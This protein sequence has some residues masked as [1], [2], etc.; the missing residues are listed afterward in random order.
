[1]FN[2]N[3]SRNRRRMCW[4]V[5]LSLGITLSMPFAAWSAKLYKWIDENG[6][7]RYSDR[8]PADQSKKRFQTLAPDGRVLQTKEEA[9]SPE[10]LRQEREEKQR[11]EEEARRIE[12][13][14][15]RIQAE[16]DH[17]DRV[18]MMTFTS[19][20]EI[21]EAQ[22]ERLEV[23]DSV[24]RLLQRDIKQEEDK[25]ERLHQSAQ[26]NYLDKGREVPGGLAQNIEYSSDKILS[27]QRQLQLKFDERERIKEQ[28]ANDLVRYR[29]LS[30]QQ[31]NDNASQGE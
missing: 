21:V 15:R 16:K 10:Q 3:S 23:I 5:S 25:L 8:L 1:M 22:N 17:H 29:E 27:K 4:L 19:E 28:Y 7:I 14:K 12:A 26:R 6:N 13:E 20:D 9:K 30:Q 31:K 24:I 2:I 11:Q 18:L